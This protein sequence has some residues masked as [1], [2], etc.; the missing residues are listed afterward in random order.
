MLLLLYNNRMV[1]VPTPKKK[2]LSRLFLKK[3]I[4]HLEEKKAISLATT[5][6]RAPLM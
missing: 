3:G 1:C 4:H 5:V 2:S 6:V